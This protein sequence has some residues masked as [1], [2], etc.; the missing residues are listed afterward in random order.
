MSFSSRLS[1]LNDST[2]FCLIA[3]EGVVR[4]FTGGMSRH[5][6]L[7]EI[8]R[9]AEGKTVLASISMIPFSQMKE[10][11]FQVVDDGEKIL[12][13]T[14]ET[15][16]RVCKDEFLARVPQGDAL[17]LKADITYNMNDTEFAQ[18]VHDVVHNEIRNGSGCNFLISR[19]SYAEL[20]SVTY[21]KMLALFARLLRNEFGAYMVYLFFDGETYFIGA[22]PEGHLSIDKKVA[23]MRPICG[24][25]SKALPD[26]KS[27]LDAFVVD[28]NEI[29]ELF[30]VV[31]ETLKMMMPLCPNGGDVLGPTL[32]EMRSVIHTENLLEGRTDWDMIDAF[33]STMFAPTM[34]G[35]PMESA[36]RVIYK[37]E[38]GQG[39]S[40]YSSAVLL[41]GNDEEGEECLDSAITIRSAQI[42]KDGQLRL[43]VG[44]SI[45]RDSDPQKETEEVKAKIAGLLKALT[46][47][48]N[49][50]PI[51]P[52]LYSNQVEAK[53]LQRNG[54]L[55]NFWIENQ[56]LADM[57]KILKGKVIC[58]I[59]NEDDFVHMAAHLL[60]HMGATTQVIDIREFD[61][62]A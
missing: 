9:K 22:S 16:D 32:R 50:Q 10:R 41:L 62:L 23:R 15:E 24:T 34:V 37:A 20:E 7:A 53:M 60:Q 28:E 54:R 18:T 29:N 19:C 25:L 40:Y 14:P 1:T 59:N 36:A 35:S 57:P 51:L 47:D 5:A 12:T 27:A 56:S 46:S 2:P 58:L 30:M 11:G 44:A 31:D 43:Q 3:K 49:D 61:E 26:M 42:S 38:K 17:T 21:D 13:L 4:L 8:P 39:R 48:S 33:R 55:S 6:K 52:D 45:V